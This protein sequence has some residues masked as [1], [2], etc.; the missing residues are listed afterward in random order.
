MV[1]G[2][3]AVDAMEFLSF[4]PK[5]SAKI[6][7]DAVKSA[8]ANAEHNAKQK[9]EELFVDQIQVGRAMKIKRMRFV[10]RSRA[11]RYVKHRANVKVVLATK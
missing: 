8:V 11:H 1:R 3:P 2:K 6:L 7:L 10:G 9:R 5:R 4:L